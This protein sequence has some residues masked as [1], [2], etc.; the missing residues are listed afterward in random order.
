M[1]S[2]KNGDRVLN[3]SEGSV[4]TMVEIKRWD[5]TQ[6]WYVIYLSKPKLTGARINGKCL[7]SGVVNALQNHLKSK[8]MITVKMVDDGSNR[9]TR[10]KGFV[11]APYWGPI[12]AALVAPVP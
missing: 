6:M 5:F 10:T 2:T 8:N 9:W 7:I 4:I 1:P 12:S 3:T 11:S